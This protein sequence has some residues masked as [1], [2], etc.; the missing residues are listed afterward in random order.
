MSEAL[1][2]ALHMLSQRG[3]DRVGDPD[4]TPIELHHNGTLETVRVMP[5]E[6]LLWVAQLA[7]VRPPAPADAD[8]WYVIDRLRVVGWCE[9]RSRSGRRSGLE[10]RGCPKFLMYGSIGDATEA[11]R[12][13][14]MQD[15]ALR[16]ERMRLE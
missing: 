14:N 4:A 5:D 16:Q 8:D 10:T 12:V 13:L 3:W 2:A 1:R 9:V 7:P 6:V 15:S 11:A